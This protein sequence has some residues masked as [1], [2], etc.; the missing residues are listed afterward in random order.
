MKLPTCTPPSAGAIDLTV[1]AGVVEF[2]RG[3]GVELGV[4]DGVDGPEA[5][6]LATGRLGG[7]ILDAGAHQLGD[8]ALDDLQAAREQVLRQRVLQIGRG[9]EAILRARASAL[10][11]DLLELGLDL[12]VLRARCGGI[13]ALRTSSTVW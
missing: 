6:G 8:V 9:L 12:G 11:H 3:E 7:L 10:R 13:F 1:L 4:Q 2:Q 5:L